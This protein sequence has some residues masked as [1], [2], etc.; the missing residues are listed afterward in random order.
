METGWKKRS[1]KT[2]GEQRADVQG[3]LQAWGVLSGDR[4]A[5]MW[6]WFSFQW[7]TF[8]DYGGRFLPTAKG[9]LSTLWSRK[10][11]EI[12]SC[13]R[14]GLSR[15][16][17][18]CPLFRAPQFQKYC[19]ISSGFSERHQT[20]GDVLPA[21]ISTGLQETFPGICRILRLVLTLLVSTAL[22]ERSFSAM[23]IVKTGLRFSMCDA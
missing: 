19:W 22:T 20:I 1:G 21:L 17:P 18:S 14:N 3:L 2:S 12:E 13:I 4:Q 7:R 5:E 23:I 11:H 6:A 9:Q 10:Y 16:R 8:P 15:D